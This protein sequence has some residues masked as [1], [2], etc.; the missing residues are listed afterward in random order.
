MSKYAFGVDIGGT[1]VKMGLFD[2]EGNLLDAWEIKTRTE[3]DGR[4]ILDD[5][6]GSM[7]KTLE[8]KG[9]SKE[10]VIRRGDGCPRPGGRG[11]N[12]FQMRQS[13]LECF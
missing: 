9:I 10:D 3:D 1:T 5:I 7:E 11:R 2:T 4:H 12:C 13:R 6:A 8:I